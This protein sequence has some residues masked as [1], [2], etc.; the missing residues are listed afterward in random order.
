MLTFR[1]QCN[2]FHDIFYL[3]MIT[4]IQ[5]RPFRFAAWI[6][7]INLLK[8]LVPRGDYSSERVKVI[9]RAKWAVS[10]NSMI[11]KTPYN[12]NNNTKK[13][14]STKRE[15]KNKSNKMTYW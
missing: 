1:Y 14:I 5:A 2:T 8:G 10:S 11:E 6:S 12:V 3:G 15:K 13:I 4:L 7:L 9:Y